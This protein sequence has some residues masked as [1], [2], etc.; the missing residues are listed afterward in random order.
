MQNLYDSNDGKCIIGRYT[1]GGFNI[2]IYNTG[3][4]GLWVQDVNDGIT[5]SSD[6]VL[7][8]NKDIQHIIFNIRNDNVLYL[9]VDNNEYTMDYSK[10]DASVSNIQL[11]T[12][13]SNSMHNNVTARIYSCKLWYNDVMLYDLIPV[14]KH[15]IGYM[16]NKL[17]DMLFSNS[18]NSIK[19]FILGPDI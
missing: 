1:P 17:T 3:K 15:G 18:P 4:I 14:R 12:H 2:K 6:D 5:L 13:R 9:K 11:F 8:F 7:S 16:Y 10:K 19:P